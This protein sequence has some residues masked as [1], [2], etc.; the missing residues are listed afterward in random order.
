M[1]LKRLSAAVCVMLLCGCGAK[2][3]DT[4]TDFVLDTVVTVSVYD[5]LPAKDYIELIKVYE[6][7]FS[8]TMADSDIAKINASDGEPVK[9]SPGTIEILESCRKY[10]EL[11]G[12]RIDP[13]IGGVSRL[14]DFHGGGSVPDEAA[15]EEALTHVGFDKLVIDGDS[16]YLTDPETELDLGFI[17]KGYIGEK[18]TE[19]EMCTAV[20]DLGGNISV[21]GRKPG[22]R[23]FKIGI[24]KPFSGGEPIVTAEVSGERHFVTSGI[25]ERYFEEDGKLYHHILDAKTG[26]PVE[27]ELYSVTVVTDDGIAAD[28]LS[29][30]CFVLGSTDGMKLIEDTPGAEALFIDKNMEITVSS[31]FPEYTMIR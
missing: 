1:K 12:G 5:G 3:A 27:N 13:T 20:F 29:T 6:K 28:A 17:A 26:Y 19:D 15:I 25:Y 30:T 10:Y 7:T 9:V 14:W 22:G 11:S 24:E 8:A 23:P 2:S 31:G 16:V 4:A 18:L 21:C